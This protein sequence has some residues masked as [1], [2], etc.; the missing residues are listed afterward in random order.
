[1]IAETILEN[2]IFQGENVQWEK[3]NLKWNTG[4][5]QLE[6]RRRGVQPSSSPQGAPEV[7]WFSS[8]TCRTQNI[9]I[10][11]AV[12]YFSK[13]YKTKSTKGKEFKSRG[14]KAQPSKSP[15]LE[16]S[17]RASWKNMSEMLSTREAH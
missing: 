7:Q 13:R 4:V 15:L 6:N 8:R 5:L 12:I 14:N 10:F 1:M 17:H 2:V 16:E 11:T 3:V 9:V